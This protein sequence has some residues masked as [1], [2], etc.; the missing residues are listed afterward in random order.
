MPGVKLGDFVHV[1]LID[2]LEEEQS[3]EAILRLTREATVLETTQQM[4]RDFLFAVIS[5]PT[6][7]LRR[8]HRVV[9]RLKVALSWPRPRSS[10]AHFENLLL[11]FLNS[12]KAQNEN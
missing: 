12:S 8:E 10:S 3:L 2:Q 7:L 4:R 6:P 1:L 5:R 9:K 11:P